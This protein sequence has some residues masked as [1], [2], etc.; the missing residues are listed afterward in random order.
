MP[1]VTD[2]LKMNILPVVVIYNAD[3]HQT[4][5]WCSLLSHVGDCQILVYDNS[6]KPLNQR[7]ESATVIYHHDPDNGGVSAA[8]NFG[9]HLACQNG[10]YNTLLLLDEDTQFQPDYLSVLEQAVKSHSDISLFVPQLLFGEDMPFSPSHRGIRH[11][12]GALLSEGVYSLTDYL[13]VNSG[14]CIRL[15]AFVQAGGY[16]NDIR[17]DFADFDF[18]SRL[19][20]VSDRFCL[21]DSVAR[22]SFSNEEKSKEHL[23]RRFRLY[24]EGARH[25]RKNKLISNMVRI[26]VLRHT[27]ALTCRTRST[28]FFTYLFK[29]I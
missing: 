2:S 29:N 12:R 21:V 14:A 4:N 26:D 7:Y 19:A 3:F 22:Q 13:P 1:S 8:Y 10:F 27:L 23:F 11:K 6:P 20:L 17:L 18:F 5:I 28:R 9:A 25:A 15:S 24:V 16:N